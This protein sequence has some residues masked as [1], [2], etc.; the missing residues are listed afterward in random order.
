MTATPQL[1]PSVVLRP[2]VVWVGILESQQ[3]KK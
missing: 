2:N 3:K 1:L